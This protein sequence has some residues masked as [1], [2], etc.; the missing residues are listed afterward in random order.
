MYG[1]NKPFDVQESP[2][3]T[4]PPIESPTFTMKGIILFTLLVFILMLLYLNREYVLS[5]LKRI[6]T[7]FSPGDKIDE[8]EEAYNEFTKNSTLF[9][10]IM[11]RLDQTEVNNKE[12]LERT[13]TMNKETL[14]RTEKMH[15]E[16]LDNLQKNSPT[17]DPSK[18]DAI[19]SRLDSMEKRSQESQNTYTPEPTQT[20]LRT[21]EQI[22]KERKETEKQIQQGGLSQIEDRLAQYR[23]DQIANYDGFC[24]IGYDRKRE[25]TNIYEGDICMSG[26]IFPTMEIC[27]NPTPLR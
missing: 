26:Q 5:F 27:V 20:P 15:K 1:K 21:I 19:Q 16:T 12:T 7:D 10:D 3:P 4:L 6:Y 9:Q 8:L 13:E 22:E 23:K 18:L 24:Y 17:L 11:G 14:E 25:C 2:K